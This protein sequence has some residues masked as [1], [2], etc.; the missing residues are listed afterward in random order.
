MKRK[1][2]NPHALKSKRGIFHFLLWQLGFYKETRVP[3]PIPKDFTFP[4]VQ[5]P[6][7][8]LQPKVT[9][10]NH[11]TFWVQYENIS[12]L[13]DPIW[14]KRCSPFKFF[15]PERKLRPPIPIDQ[16]SHVDF[17]LISHDHYDHLDQLT[18]F[19]LKLHY[20]EIIWIV[21]KGVKKRFA[22]WFSK[23]ELENVF[24]LNWWENIVLKNVRITAVPAQ[25]FSGRGLF[26][27]NR[28][29]WM[30]S[31]CQFSKEKQFYFAGDTGYNPFD[32]K[33]IR[34]KL[35]AMDLSLIPIGVYAPRKFMK[36][37]HI[38]PKE[39][40]LI[41]QDVGSKLSVG[42][43]WGTF[44]LSEEALDRPPF[45]LFLAL[46]QAGISHEDFRVLNPG[47]TINW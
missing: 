10:I 23:R 4:N 6:L 1:Y 13:T 7:N 11:S 43:H 36:P 46:Q 44:Q 42:G 2:I 9:W 25:H 38:N 5:K 20:P 26:D 27:R 12:I 24:E 33:E 3:A 8:S 41:H 34:K 30:G 16:F 14:H 35:G 22:R 17:V 29:Q 31:V 15:G 37:I 39:S 19:D 32:F 45:D 28:S 47:Q 21:P 40:V 18:V